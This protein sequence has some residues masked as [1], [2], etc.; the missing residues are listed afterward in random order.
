MRDL[1]ERLADA[2]RRKTEFLAV[3]AHE[4]RNPLAPLRNC[5]QIL[6]LHQADPAVAERARSM[7]E[8]Q[9]SHLVLLVDDL[10][11]VARITQGKLHLKRQQVDLSMVLREAVE[12]S[13]VG[14]HGASHVLSV[15]LP[16][17][18]VHVD[19]DP[20]RLTQILSN[21]LHNASKYTPIGGQIH[22]SLQQEADA[23]VI[24]VSDTGVGI[25]ASFM[26]SIFDMFSQFS[27]LRQSEQGGLGIGLALVRSL[28]ELH[29]GTVS[30]ASGG[31]DQ[32]STFTVRLPTIRSD[33]PGN[34][35]LSSAP[36]EAVERA[37][38]I[39]VVDDNVDAADSLGEMLRGLGHSTRIAHDGFEA[40]SLAQ[41]YQPEL[42]ILDIGMPRMT[43][44]EVAIEMRKIPGLETT[45]IVAL[46]GW[47]AEEDRAQ[48]RQAGF[49]HHLTKPAS[50]AAFLQLFDELSVR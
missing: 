7:M 33:S 45:C 43:G 42:V 27:S 34:P 38:R 23:A 50:S 49:D 21:L 40:L 30:A 46:T 5:L 1:A 6:S 8:R 20:M 32:G 35:V 28:V 25:P 44:Y 18:S 13:R 24:V 37:R 29:G 41:G 48:S 39:L 3:L 26:T 15:D 2:N 22:L 16:R 14:G 36:A 47:G 9:L 19:G 12:A 31:R 10:L 11:D 17:E 4:L